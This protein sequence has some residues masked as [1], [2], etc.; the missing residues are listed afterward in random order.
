[1]HDPM[2]VA[3]T[4]YNPI[5]RRAKR[6]DSSPDKKRLTLGRK[7]Y[8]NAAN[9]GEPIFHWWLPRAWE[10]RIAGRAFEF[11]ELVVIW[12]VEPGGHDSGDIC[13]HYTRWQDAEGAWQMKHLHGWKF[14]VHHWKVTV[15]PL[16]HLHRAVVQRCEWCDGRSTKK[17]RVDIQSSWDGEKGRHWWSSHPGVYHSGCLTATVIHTACVCEVPLVEK[18]NGAYGTCSTC[19]RKYR[20]EAGWRGYRAAIELVGAPVPG[21]M[22]TW[23]RQI[24]V[25]EI[26]ERLDAERAAETTA[27]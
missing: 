21:K 10:P 24:N 23:P 9:L 17:H 3:F 19:H 20:D 15:R 7:R 27:S 4:I 18:F 16:Q 6:K 8:V 13:K 5:P 11:R 1:M 25:H 14:H 26:R 22:W 2:T 12:H